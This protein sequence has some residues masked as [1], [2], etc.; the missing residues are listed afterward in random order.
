[1]TTLTQEEAH[2]LFEYK[3]GVLFWKIRPALCKKI[4]DVVGGTNGT[5]QPYLRSRYKNQ[6]FMV[7]QIVFLMHHGFLPKII[8]HIDGNIQNNKIEN[9]REATAS[10]NSHNQKLHVNNKSG[11]RCV[12]WHKHHQAWMVKVALNGK[13]I[14]TKYLKDFEL[15]CLVADEARDLFH[16]KYAFKGA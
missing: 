7:H 15:A 6:R 16:G 10:Q 13:S 3:D 1:M 11:H 5:K 14:V 12:T 8:D 4:G 9:L 2:R